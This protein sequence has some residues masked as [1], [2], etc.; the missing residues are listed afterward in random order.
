MKSIKGYVIDGGVLLLAALLFLSAW[1]FTYK[2]LYTDNCRPH[3]ITV[4]TERL[5]DRHAA[6]I[7]VGDAVYDNITKREI[8]KI[9]YAEV[10]GDG[11]MKLVIDARAKPRSASLRTS[12]VWFTYSEVKT[13]EEPL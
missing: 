1:I 2:I 4:V 11:R 6:L 5:P 10:L 7:S 8:G 3:S 12:D 9:T 13:D